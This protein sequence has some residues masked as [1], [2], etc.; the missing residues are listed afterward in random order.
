MVRCRQRGARAAPLA[1]LS[2]AVWL[3]MLHLHAA[4]AA[5]IISASRL[6]T[7]VLDGSIIV[8]ARGRVALCCSTNAVL[9]FCT[10]SSASH[11]THMQ[12][13]TSPPRQPPP[14]SKQGAAPQLSCAQ[15]LVMALSV[16]SGDAAATSSIELTL[17]CVGSPSGA[18]PCPCD[19]STDLGCTCRLVGCAWLFV[20]VGWLNG[21]NWL[22]MCSCTRNAAHALVKH[23]NGLPTSPPPAGTS[24]PRCAST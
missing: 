20:V 12:H 13:A 19:Y 9:A 16:D 22:A 4:G 6:E 11:T 15:K 18:C 23:A 1:G 7:C 2:A 3:W 17:S 8:R 10:L 24:P 21:H 14:S 5:D